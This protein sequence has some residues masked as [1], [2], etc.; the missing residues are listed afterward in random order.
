MILAILVL[1]ISNPNFAQTKEE[2][3]EA[4]AAR[5]EEKKLLKAER[6][7]ESL[8]QLKENY[9][10]SLS[11][12]KDST[13]VIE[14]HTLFD[15]RGNSIPVSP[16]I[17]FV[18]V[19]G[20]DFTMQVGFNGR[21][22]ANGVGGTTIEGRITDYRILDED[23]FITLRINVSTS[24]IGTASVT[25]NVGSDG[26]AKAYVTGSFRT[27]ISFAGKITPLEESVVYKGLVTY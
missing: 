17:N 16:S 7:N 25:I 2:K 21:I 23:G 8:K 27:R 10:I 18:M 19:E 14:T 15:R 24:R 22:G 20:N 12:I 6:K 13:F 5:K 11:N 9:E 1:V 26:H 3:L 4:K